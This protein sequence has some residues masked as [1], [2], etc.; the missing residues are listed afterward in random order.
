[1]S[2]SLCDF[3]QKIVVEDR[4]VSDHM[5]LDLYCNCYTDPDSCVGEKAQQKKE[6]IFWRE[7]KVYNFKQYIA[8]F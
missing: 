2:I 6:K 1:M 8:S 7:D 3:V 4:I 5:R